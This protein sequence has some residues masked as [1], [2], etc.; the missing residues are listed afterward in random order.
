MWQAF[1]FW[2]AGS[3]LV[4][5]GPRLGPHIATCQENYRAKLDHNAN[6]ERAERAKKR[7]ELGCGRKRV[8][9]EEAENV[10][11]LWKAVF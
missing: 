3:L 5:A 7:Y 6:A 10:E 4:K 8:R 9:T 2:E 11:S 1:C